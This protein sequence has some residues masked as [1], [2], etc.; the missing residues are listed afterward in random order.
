[1]VDGRDSIQAAS[2]D[3][4]LAPAVL[5]IGGEMQFWALEIWG[6]LSI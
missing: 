1:M 2:S 6:E 4:V 3:E 5:L